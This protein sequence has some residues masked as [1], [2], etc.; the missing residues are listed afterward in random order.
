VATPHVGYA[1]QRRSRRI[2][3]TTILT[4]RGMDAS[5]ARYVEKVP[6]LTLSC[7]GCRYRSK[8]EV[9]LGN[10]VLLELT[11]TNG[12][13]LN[14]TQARVKWLQETMVGK[15]RVW[16]VAVELEEPGNFWG[17][18][19]PPEDWSQVT[20]HKMMGRPKSALEV[21]VAPRSEQQVGPVPNR[22]D[23]QSSVLEPMS[24][25]LTPCPEGLSEHVRKL[26]SEAVAAAVVRENGSLIEQFR[27]QLQDE[28]TNTLERVVGRCKEELIHR[29]LN[30]LTEALEASARNIQVHWVNKLEEGLNSAGLRMTAQATEVSDR[31]GGI[32]DAAIERLQLNAEQSR[33]EMIEELTVRSLSL[34]E[35]AEDFLRQSAQEFAE[36]MQRRS[37]ELKNQFGGDVN[38][39]LASAD[40]ELKQKSTAVVDQSQIALLKISEC[41]Q[42]NVQGELKVLA[43]SVVERTVNTLNE[44]AAEISKL[45]LSQLQSHTRRYLE[46]VSGSIAEISTKIA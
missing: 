35:Q 6:T 44:Q 19:S 24:A 41:C 12:G 17:V 28:M 10:L 46:S 23:A 7:H 34:C 45:G 29:S 39:L 32:A 43:A 38:E 14:S 25:S 2:D 21:Q 31:I 16:D 11:G 22:A 30:Q 13:L 8:H 26:V 40:R 33:R 1:Q 5:Q 3:Q 9:L 15:Q 4:V 20:E 36:Q 37:I 18:A 27:A 42:E